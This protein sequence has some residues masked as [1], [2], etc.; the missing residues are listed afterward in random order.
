MAL[1]RSTDACF[2]RFTVGCWQSENDSRQA[3]IPLLFTPPSAPSVIFPFSL[4][5]PSPQR[6]LPTL[7]AIR[8]GHVPPFHSAARKSE[9]TLLPDEVDDAAGFAPEQLEQRRRQQQMRE[10]LEADA[11]ESLGGGAGAEGGRG[12]AAGGLGWDW[13]LRLYDQHVSY[14]GMS[15][16]PGA[17]ALLGD[18]RS[19]M[20]AAGGGGA[21]GARQA[22]EAGEAGQ[23]G[24]GRVSVTEAQAAE[25]RAEA[26]MRRSAKA[27]QPPAS[28]I[29]GAACGGANLAWYEQYG[30]PQRVTPAAPATAVR[31]K[32]GKKKGS[33][34]TTKY[35]NNTAAFA[36]A[37]LQLYESDME[38]LPATGVLFS[39]RL[40][41]WG[42]D[43]GGVGLGVVGEAGGVEGWAG[44]VS[45]AQ[46]CSGFRA[47]VSVVVEQREEGHGA[48]GHDAAGGDT[49][50][51]GSSS[52]GDGSSG[53]EGPGGWAA[54]E[55]E[56]RRE[57]G[58]QG[59][60][61]AGRG[62]GGGGGGGTWRRVLRHDAEV[63][64]LAAPLPP[65]LP[66]GVW[67]VMDKG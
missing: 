33:A 51:S 23:G 53:D 45:G 44:V 10:A 12:D 14:P 17:L 26:V 9:E 61:G 41:R 37:V 19:V 48:G 25:A 38:G 43:W 46:P 67:P 59:R 36:P 28:V 31:S 11:R 27:F 54:L 24:G 21:V 7:E 5:H 42:G 20:S 1:T 32:K 47:W 62:G 40:G 29:G 35:G 4:F 30:Q 13:V 58:Q 50:G 3:A 22:G 16:L 57:L 60:A 66:E 63:T 34:S 49:E 55:A 65:L 6:A 64:G 56:A 15:Y 18:G 8:T 2:L 52:G 39:W